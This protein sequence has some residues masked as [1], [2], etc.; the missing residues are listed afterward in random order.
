MKH[1]LHDGAAAMEPMPQQKHE[2]GP[3]SVERDGFRAHVASLPPWS[4]QRGVSTYRV[5]SAPESGR[6]YKTEEG[7]RATSEEIRF[8]K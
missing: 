5:F 6:K 3:G 7:G 4:Y 8:P 1:Q 2:Q